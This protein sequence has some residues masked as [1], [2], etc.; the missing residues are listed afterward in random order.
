[1]A[2]LV[3]Q[4]DNGGSLTVAYDGDRDGSAIFSSDTNEGIDR[5][6]S[7]SFRGGDISIEKSVKQEGLRQQYITADGKV[8]RVADGGRYG[9]LK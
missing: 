1:M 4:W 7:V 3:K 6:M 9:V 8:Y 2:E 5:E